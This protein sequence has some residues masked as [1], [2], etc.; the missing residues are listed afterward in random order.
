MPDSEVLP[1]V[2]ST[3]AGAPV[4]SPAGTGGDPW[5]DKF[6]NADE[7]WKGYQ[8]LEKR[9]G[10]QGNELGNYKTAYTDVSGKAQ[11]YDKAVTAWDDWFKKTIGPNWDDIEKFLKTKEGKQAAAQLTGQPQGNQP[12]HDA[13]SPQSWS[14]GWET[15]S[16]Q[17]QAQRIQQAAVTQIANALAPS[18]RQ[19][20]TGF[21]EQYQKDMASKEQYYQ[22]YLNL[23]RRV[24]DMR[25]KD[26]T[27]DVDAVLDNAVKVLSGGADP[28][29][30]GRTLTTM[31]G[32]KEAYG[33]EMVAK[34]RIDWENEQKNKQM[35]AVQPQGGNSPAFKMPSAGT[36][37]KGGLATMRE[38][39]LK[40]ILEKHG[41]S[42]L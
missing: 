11:E 12:V 28:I 30:V 15:M 6:K 17:Q 31:G 42:V 7:A 39:V 9:L 37:T 33:K 26:P 4:A 24:M 32:D 2:E 19:W 5:G 13:G 36:G 14:E 18:L 10:T 20:Q 21:T 29:E 27:L 23:Y 25:M 41:P 1:K 22:N 34:A 8:E 3:G 40:Q 38:S 16:P 35:S